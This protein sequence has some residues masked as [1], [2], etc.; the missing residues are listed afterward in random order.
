[1]QVVG[2]VLFMNSAKCKLSFQ[3]HDTAFPHPRVTWAHSSDTHSSHTVRIG[4]LNGGTLKVFSQAKKKKLLAVNSIQ[5]PC[6]RLMIYSRD[7]KIHS[8][9]FKMVGNNEKIIQF[10]KQ[11][12][13]HA[14]PDKNNLF[15]LNYNLKVKAD[16]FS[17]E[18]PMPMFIQQ[19]DWQDELTRIDQNPNWYVTS[20]NENFQLSSS[21]P[22]YFIIPE[23]LNNESLTEMAM[24]FDDQRLLS[25][26]YSSSFGTTLARMSCLKTGMNTLIEKETFLI[27]AVK[28]STNTA[29]SVFDLIECCPSVKDIGLSGEKL[30]ELCM[31]DCSKDFWNKDMCWLSYLEETKWLSY[32]QRCLKQAVRIVKMMTCEKTSVILKEPKSRDISCLLSCLVQLLFDRHYRTILGFQSLIQREW[33]SMGHPFQE[34]CGFVNVPGSESPVFL[35]FLDCV[36]QLTIQFPVQFEFTETYLTVLWDS[37]HTG[38]FGTFLFSCQHQHVLENC[39]SMNQRCGNSATNISE[40]CLPSIW[41]MLANAS[42]KTLFYNPLYVIYNNQICCDLANS[43]KETYVSMKDQILYPQISLTKLW[44]QC[45]IRWLFP[46]QINAGGKISVYLQQCLLVEEIFT[47][48]NQIS[49]L[50]KGEASKKSFPDSNLVFASSL[51][52]VNS[53][54][55]SSFPFSDRHR[56]CMYANDS[57]LPHLSLNIYKQSSKIISPSIQVTTADKSTDQ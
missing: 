13:Q 28:K 15:V 54:I 4:T 38:L 57:S 45:Y 6:K 1:M 8:Y 16:E 21:L 36:W 48:Q 46:G 19:K 12:S 11:M 25:W 55:T 23:S 42:H 34:R 50:S 30:R 2:I 53:K 49:N 41:R 18:P 33:V 47:L 39:K 7:F 31:T 29:V 40:S 20:A 44:A 52:D 26:S 5:Q 56:I 32:V 27:N 51:A 37:L 9:G 24:A 17:A 10:L 3:V 43:I 14:F 35:L 22:E